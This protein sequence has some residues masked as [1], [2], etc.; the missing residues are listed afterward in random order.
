MLSRVLLQTVTTL[1]TQPGVP[2]GSPSV[3]QAS[4]QNGLAK[5]DVQEDI[6]TELEKP[7]ILSTEDVDVARSHEIMNKA[8]SAILMLLLK[9]F[10]LS[11]ELI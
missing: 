8:V 9:W 10:K 4:D 11:R 2:N 6:I 7:I 1:V 5:A 3:Q